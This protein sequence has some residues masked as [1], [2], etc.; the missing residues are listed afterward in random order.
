[1]REYQLTVLLDP[2]LEPSLLKHEKDT[3]IGIVKTASSGEPHVEDWGVKRVAYAIERDREA[4]ILNLR[5]Q[6]EPLRIRDME[7]S[8][9]L[10]DR[11]R[12]FM[13]SRLDP[14]M[15][16]PPPARAAAAGEA[17]APPADPPGQV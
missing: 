12:R 3:V 5:F 13:V 17:E 14:A 9:R 16:I 11:V 7:T 6:A 1:M 8:L 10:R 15:R 4:A 2:G